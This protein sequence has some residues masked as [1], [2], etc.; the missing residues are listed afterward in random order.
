MKLIKRHYLFFV[1]LTIVMALC[2][3]SQ[4]SVSAQAQ[5]QGTFAVK[6]STVVPKVTNIVRANPTSP[7]TNA[8]KVY[9]TATFSEAVTGVDVSD[10]VLTASVTG[11][12]ISG[13]TG[14]GSTYSIAVNTGTGNG[15]IHL[16]VIDNDTIRNSKNIPLGG[17]GIV[18]G[19]YTAG[20]TYTIDRI[21]P[22][23]VSSVRVNPG[24]VN[25]AGVGFTVTFSEDVTG[26]DAADFSFT[27]TG[28][29]SPA[30]T[31]VSGSG[32]T[33]TVTVK[34]IGAGTL[35]LNVIDNDTIRDTA[36]NKLGGTGAGNGNYTAGQTYTIDQVA[37]KVVSIVRV[38]PSHTNLSSVNFTVTFSEPVTGVNKS[39]FDLTVTGITGASISAVSGTG[40]TYKVTV[41]TGTGNGTLRLNVID[42]D[43]ILDA[44]GNKLGGKGA[45]NGNY[46]TGQTYTIE[47]TVPKVV[48]I[49]RVNPSYTNLSSVNFTVTFSEA[50]MGVDKADFSITTSGITGAQVTAISNTGKKRTVTVSTGTGSGTL[51][52]NVK[53]NDT[54]RDAAGNKLGGTGVGNG[55]YTAGQTYTIDRRAPKVASI[56]R[57]NPSRTNLSSVKFTVTFS[58]IVTGVDKADFSLTSTG[59]NGASITAVSGS[60]KTRTVTVGTGTGSGTLRLDVVDNDTILDILGYMLGGTG[61]GNGNY[62]AG[63]TY[64]IDRSAPKVVSSVRVNSSPTNRTSVSF[65]VT[66]SEAVTG[67]DKADFSLT[68]TGSITGASITAVSGSGKTRTVTVSTGKGNGTLRLNVKD[69]DT[70]ID[71]LGYKLGGAGIGNGSYTAGQTYTIDKRAPKVISSVLASINPTNAG[72]VDFTVTFSEA[73]TRVDMADFSLTLTGITGASITAV[74]GTG[75]TYTV[76]VSTGAGNGTLRLNVKDNDTVLD[77]A[78]NKL[79][80][81]GAGNGNYTAG[82]T[83]TIDKTAPD[84]QIN[85][86][87]PV[88]SSSDSATFT[89]SSTEG[90]ATFECSLDSS[91]YAPCSSGETYNGLAEGPHS[92][93][94]RAID[95]A[96]NV[97]ASPASFTWTID[98]TTALVVS[99]SLPASTDLTNADS[100]D[101]TVTFS[102]V[103]TGVDAADFGIIST[104]ITGASITAVNGTGTTY[105]VTVSTGTGD[106]T[107]GLDVVDDYVI[108]DETGNKLDGTG[109][110][111]G[112]YTAGQTYTIDKTAPDTQINSSPPASS[113]SDSAAFTFS[114]TEGTA[115]FEC[116]LDSSAYASCS[117]GEIIYDGLV[118]G[119]HS[120]AVRAADQA[121]NVDASPASFTWTIDTTVPTV[122]SSLPASTNPTNADSVD[123]TVTFSEVVTGVDAA[124][125]SI[126]S[127]GITGA[128]VTG[129]T[130]SGT[131]FTVSVN[132]GTGSGDLYL[133]V[134]DDDTILDETG[135]K[136]GGTSTGNGNYTAGQPYTVTKP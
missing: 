39:D 60:G 24:I 74:N 18:N 81:T 56:V 107:L 71:I 95:Q 26:V 84:T 131:S 50:V 9:F 129:V 99:S 15:M 1:S 104:G 112:N 47:K 51:R 67:V 73:V 119:L 5:A 130:G 105:K 12:S 54:I 20:Q 85:S 97:D 87:P 100:V 108:L 7:S 30:I 106:G 109:A 23:V 6:S 11:A 14:S 35:R 102:E 103:V 17:A 115:T 117:S 58:E 66:F 19:T 62:T 92:F 126:T 111:N 8:T 53:D 75:T 91:A 29:L 89:F 41:S 42:D 114:S 77:A 59:I 76:T 2:F 63:Q 57:V 101:F 82:Q 128:F 55:S 86:S 118:E 80:G 21:A 98:T 96:N 45:D 10:F 136:L 49:V 37:P 93:E 65:T 135:N 25:Y 69:N 64:T 48:S 13:V 46:T 27:S 31:S 72:S 94:V 68:R 121:N 133:D 125:F 116:S 32:T 40:T 34:A 52:L 3:V 134:V 43:T 122:S 127:T 113:S 123:F 28:A 124:D 16:D 70:I 44:V 79:G 90:T 83:Y 33:R 61:A 22:K 36:G 110:G 4:N 78:R 38:N 132:T 88:L 120:F